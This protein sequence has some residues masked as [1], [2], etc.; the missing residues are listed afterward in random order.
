MTRKNPFPEKKL[1]NIKSNVKDKHLIEVRRMEI[2]KAAVDLFVRKGF[3]KTTVREIAQRFGMSVG[4]L[5]EYIR[6]KEDILFL[7]CDY[8]HTSVSMR[9]K[10]SLK[11]TSDNTETL[12]RAI[13]IYLE[14]ID[15]MQDYIIFLYQETKSLS[16]EARKYIFNAEDE[17]TQIFEEILLKGSKDGEFSI[18][19]KDILL[20]AHNIMVLGQMWAFRRWV[21]QKNY[22]LERYIEIQTSSILSK[23]NPD[24]KNLD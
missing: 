23:I 20:I 6:T 19:K 13:K 21:I 12:K 10:P 1:K 9:V 2:V 5:Y 18:D 11:I 3:H 17:M 16:K 22:T 7:V 14:I 8:I 24:Y 4:T 15:E